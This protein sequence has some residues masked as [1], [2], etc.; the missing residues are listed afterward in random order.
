MNSTS[1][2]APSG[3]VWDP[4]EPDPDPGPGSYEL[5]TSMGKQFASNYATTPQWSITSKHAKSWAKVYAGPGSDKVNYG[6]QSPGAI[7]PLKDEFGVHPERSMWGRDGIKEGAHC[8]PVKKQGTDVWYN[9]TKD[10]LITPPQGK[11]LK[12]SYGTSERFP[13]VRDPGIGPGQYQHKSS[14]DGPPGRTFGTSIRA[15]DRVFVSE[16]ESGVNYRGRC[17]PGPGP[18]RQ[19]F[20]KDSLAFQMSLDKKLKPVKLSD[21]P[22]HMGPGYY[23]VHNVKKGVLSSENMSG[24]AP[25]GKPRRKK[26]RFDFKK[27][28]N[29]TDRMAFHF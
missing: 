9:V 16:F 12:T 5:K 24:G 22:Q 6:K 11:N 15:Y 17:S 18:Y 19:D 23:A 21:T 7:Y 29:Q 13:D 3:P 28:R 25:F 2:S 4:E 14:L 27:L 8:K 1:M 20:G 26:W 10:N